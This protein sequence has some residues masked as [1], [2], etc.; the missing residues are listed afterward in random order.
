MEFANKIIGQFEQ[1][2]TKS[3]IEMNMNCTDISESYTAYKDPLCGAVKDGFLELLA[4]RVLSL[5]LE[6][7]LCILGI[8][9]VIR[10]KVDVPKYV[11]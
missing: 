4:L 2:G 11:K 10:N 5:P 8:R 3:S 1:Y 7:G 6:I 9:V